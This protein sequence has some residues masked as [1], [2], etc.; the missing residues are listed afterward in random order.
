MNKFI[1]MLIKKYQEAKSEDS[2]KWCRYSPTC[3]NYAIGVFSKFNFFK[4][5]FLTIYRILRCNPLSKGGY[6][7]VPLSKKEKREL[8]NSLKKTDD[9]LPKVDEKPSD[10]L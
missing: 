7:P 1:I 6:D 5:S 3:S 4:A 2:R 9:I 10:L 8:K